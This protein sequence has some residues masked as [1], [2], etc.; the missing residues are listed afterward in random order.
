[1]NKHTAYDLAQ[2]QSL[3]LEAKLV[4]TERRIREWYDHYDGNVHVS[5]SGGKD[6]TV[7]LDI[8]RKL[9]PN[10]PA[11]FVDTGLE[12]PEIKEFVKTFDNVTVLRPK[13]SFRQVIEKYGYPV[14]SKEVAER[15]EA[16]SKPDG[17]AARKFDPES[18]YIK[19][20]GERWCLAKWSWLRDSDIPISDKC[21]DEMKKKP[22]H[23]FEKETG[24]KPILGAQ[25]AEAQKRRTA[26]LQSGCNA[27]NAKRPLSSPLAFWT[28][29]DILRYIKDNALPI[30]KVYGEVVEENGKL[31]TTGVNRTGCVF[32]MFGAHLEKSPNRFERLK[33]THPQ[34]WEY[35]MKPWDEGGLGLKEVCDFCGIRTGYEEERK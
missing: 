20:Y 15:I 9:Y 21:C 32:C 24:L 30:A 4:M 31:R 16:R 26:W 35:C 6:S 14:I 11:V 29:Q 22:V 12:Y 10:I 34:L 13:M 1:M 25:A 2:M 7:L 23:R 5:F 19:R 3:P 33:K 27:F 8:C 17:Y 18:D 28:E